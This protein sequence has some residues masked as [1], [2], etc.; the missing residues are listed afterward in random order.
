[1]AIKGQSITISYRAWDTVANTWKTGDA[2]NHS[3]SLVKDGGA[4]AATTNAG[5]EIDATNM[6]GAYKVTLTATE[7]TANVIIPAGK[8][9]TAG[10]VLVFSDIVTEQGVL[11]GG[12][13][14]A[15]AGGLPTVDVNNNVH[16][17]QTAVRLVTEIRNGTAQA[18]AAGTITLDAGASAT[19]HLY[20]GEWIVLTGGTGAGQAR[21]ISG[22]VGA[23]KVATV[24]LAWTTNPD[25]TSLFTVVPSAAVA[26]VVGS[27][28]SIAG[29]TFPAN[30][31]A[32]L[33]T[34]GGI[35]STD[36]FTRLGAP[37]GASVSADIAAVKSDTA[38]ILTDV[39][40]GAGAIYTRL[41]APAGASLAADIAAVEAH[42]ANI[43]AQVGTAG[44][45]LTAVKLAATGL[46]AIS[47]A[48]PGAAANLTTWPKLLVWLFRR[49]GKKTVLD[50][51]GGTIK[52][53]ADDGV[54]VDTTQTVTDTGTVQT[55]GPVT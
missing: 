29:I 31:G 20:E 21:E 27:V 10:I 26:S 35:V 4:R 1:M 48:D 47:V 33:I 32:L 34:A 53:Y 19:D 51:T 38:T 39:N 42:A 55:Q 8:S 54:T 28:G 24:S 7:M 46:D 50:S 3:L 17:L 52:T 18:G 16:G 25:A 15:A 49:F 22:Y 45:G 12:T 36:A 6:P 14:P 11:P 2:A 43:D 9:S 5:A 23:T 30:F 41:G 13:T 37:A 44:A 40:T